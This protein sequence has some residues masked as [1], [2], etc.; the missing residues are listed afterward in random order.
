MVVIDDAARCGWIRLLK[1][2]S[3]QNC[4]PAMKEIFAAHL[5]L[6]SGEKLEFFTVDNRSGEFGQEWKY[7]CKD[8]GIETHSSPRCKNSLNDVVERAIEYL[9]QLAK[10]MI[11]HA[12]LEWK[13]YW[14]YTIQHAMYIRNRLST[15]ALPYGPNDTRP[16]SNITP[17]SA[18][19]NKKIDLKNLRVLG[20]AALPL[21]SNTN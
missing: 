15:S 17:I 21:V 18:F 5:Q 8:I 6:S 2:K 1:S 13:F 11:F 4:L 20:C 9:A 12:K 3:T 14:C 16:G 10:S 7:W 19:S